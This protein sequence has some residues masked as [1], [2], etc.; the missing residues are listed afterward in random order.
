MRIFILQRFDL[1]SVSC[2]RRV[3]C[4][5]EELLHRG[6]EVFITDFVHEQRQKEVPL[7]ADLPKLGAKII[8]LNRSI[9]HLLSNYKKILSCGFVPDIVHLWKSYPDASLLA[10]FLAKHWGVPLHYDWDDWEKGIAGELTHSK[11]VGWVA[12]QWD[13]LMP[14]LCH[15][16]SVAS[17][18]IRDAALQ[19]G[20]I[21][22]RMWDAPVGA[23]V[24]RFFPRPKNQEL[25]NRLKTV[26][27]GSSLCWTTGS[28]K[29]C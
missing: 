11:I 29:L 28:G 14:N 24:E 23:D 13:A 18:F 21:P 20:V 10:C 5:A 8:P 22:E 1:A 17:Q 3:I 12:G 19:H 7:V 26:S 16:I 6:H 2:A 9:F 15:T 27:T 25:I 4:Q